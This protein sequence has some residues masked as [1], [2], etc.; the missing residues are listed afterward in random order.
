[1]WK[2][3]FFRRFG[4]LFVGL[5][6]LNLCI[7]KL[8]LYLSSSDTR[9]QRRMNTAKRKRE[10]YWILEENLATNRDLIFETH[11]DEYKLLGYWGI[12]RPLNHRI[13]DSKVRN[14]YRHVRTGKNL[15]FL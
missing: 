2:G 4:C 8:G 5:L 12:G 7:L 3:G 6:N 15:E 10:L 13:K 14:F 9:L 1:M 11:I